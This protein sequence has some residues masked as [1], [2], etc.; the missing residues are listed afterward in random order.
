MKPELVEGS[1]FKARKVTEQSSQSST[2]LG[3]PIEDKRPAN[4]FFREYTIQQVLMGVAS[5]HVVL[6][7]SS[8]GKEEERWNGRL[9]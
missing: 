6:L 5:N 9:E 7:T 3:E 1:N 4:Y 8:S 2:V